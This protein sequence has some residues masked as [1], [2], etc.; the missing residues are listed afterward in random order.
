MAFGVLSVGCALA[1][2]IEVLIGARVL[3]GA[4]GALVTPSSLAIVVA[5]FEPT[6][7]AAAIGSW[8]AWGGIASIVGPLV[9]G[10]IVDQVSWRIFALNVPL[11]LVTLVLILAALPQPASAAARRVD[12]VGAALC[13][14]LG[15]DLRIHGGE[16]IGSGLELDGELVQLSAFWSEGGGREAFGRIARPSRRA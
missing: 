6:K 2:T 13:A 3:Q 9:G 1:P 12:F 7:R 16:V 5:A 14:G 8:T 15:E 4:A 11:V 10:V